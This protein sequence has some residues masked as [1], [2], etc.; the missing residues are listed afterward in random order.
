MPEPCAD[1]L[2]VAVALDMAQWWQPTVGGYLGRVSKT[3]I[4]EGSPKPRARRP[5][6]I[7]PRSRKAT[8]LY[9]RRRTA[10]RHRLASR[11]AAGSGNRA[12]VV[13]APHA[14]QRVGATM[15]LPALDPVHLAYGHCHV[16]RTSGRIGGRRDWLH[17]TAGR[18][19]LPPSLS[20][21]DHQPRRLAAPRVRPQL[22]GCRVA[23]GRARH[24]RFLMR[25]S[26]TGVSVR[27]EG[28]RVIRIGY[29][30]GA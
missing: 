11:H 6:T 29:G 21:R 28:S 10:Q 25:L 8:S 3:L 14:S 5:R 9:P 18:S 2:A 7:S 20:R 12:G 22:A 19:A 13:R 24:C 15:A 26:G 27:P 17:E 30:R 1:Q 23:A 4:C 16:K